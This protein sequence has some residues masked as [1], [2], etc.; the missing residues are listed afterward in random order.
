MVIKEVN[1]IDGAGSGTEL[2]IGWY[3][4]EFGALA[5]ASVRPK[6]EITFTP[7]PEPSALVLMGL[8]SLFTLVWRTET[9]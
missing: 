2:Q 1:E 3:S 6:L 5:E 9:V 7:I 4:S 8:A